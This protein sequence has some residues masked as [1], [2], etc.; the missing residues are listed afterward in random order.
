[1]SKRMQLAIAAAVGTV[2]GAS[3][4]ALRPD[5]DAL[6]LPSDPPLNCVVPDTDQ[7]L[8]LVTPRGTSGGVTCLIDGDSFSIGPAFVRLSQID[9]PKLGRNCLKQLDNLPSRCHQGIPS[10]RELST[11]LKHG[12]RCE[13][14]EHEG[15]NR[16]EAEC[17]TTDGAS[18]NE[19]MVRRGF[20]CAA[21]KYGTKYVAAEDDAKYNRRGLWA[22]A[23]GYPLTEKCRT[24]QSVGSI[25]K[26][27][28]N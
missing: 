25:G 28:K 19:E 9:T 23:G 13:A 2:V 3:A 24:R 12:A 4:V 7:P 18:V 1:M 20:A 5:V 10:A 11:L 17:V 14:S 16:W 22:K 26:N 27:K 15:Y 8:H 6:L 21:R